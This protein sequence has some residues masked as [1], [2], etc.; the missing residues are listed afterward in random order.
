MALLM[1]FSSFYDLNTVLDYPRS[2]VLLKFSIG[3]V[4]QVTP[5]LGPLKCLYW[6]A[7]LMKVRLT[8]VFFA[9]ISYLIPAL[10][11][12][13]SFN[14]S[15][16]VGVVIILVISRLG[17]VKCLREVD[18]IIKVRHNWFFST[19]YTTWIQCQTLLVPE[20]PLSEMQCGSHYL[21]TG[22]RTNYIKPHEETGRQRWPDTY[23]SWRHS[24]ARIACFT[25]V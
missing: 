18:Y 5:C 2:C 15:K 9:L 25:L 4:I 16:T 20:L 3:V 8:Q 11:V 13:R 7:Y 21:T 23:I 10:A 1:I 14:G 6:T 17:A 22:W 24:L 12:S 19:H